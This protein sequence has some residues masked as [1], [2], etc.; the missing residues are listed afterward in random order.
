MKLDET[1]SKFAVV[2]TAFHNGGTVCFTN[3]LDVAEREEHKFCGSDCE[4][5]CCGIVPVN[6]EGA[7]ELRTRKD[8]N[9]YPYYVEDIPAMYADLP[10]WEL[11]KQHYSTQ[12]LHF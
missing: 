4:C 10:T 11:G 3:S 7:K 2:K 6:E 12:G 5:G 9:G 8:R 1:N